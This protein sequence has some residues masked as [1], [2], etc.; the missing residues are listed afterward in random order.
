LLMT[1]KYKPSS[2]M[3]L[4]DYESQASLSWWRLHGQLV[5]HDST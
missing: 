5:S 3:E 2:F 4:S 1:G